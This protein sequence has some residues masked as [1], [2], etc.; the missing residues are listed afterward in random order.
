MTIFGTVLPLVVL[1]G[2]I[3]ASCLAQH[4]QWSFRFNCHLSLANK[5]NPRC[6]PA[7]HAAFWQN[8]VRR[9]ESN[10]VIIVTTV[11][12]FANVVFHFRFCDRRHPVMNPVHQNAYDPSGL[13]TKQALCFWTKSYFLLSGRIRRFKWALCVGLGIA[14]VYAAIFFCALPSANLFLN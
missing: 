12:S 6:Q 7:L 2:Q 4:K 9:R 8:A 3:S 13:L 1:D 5:I 14:V 11:I 10:L